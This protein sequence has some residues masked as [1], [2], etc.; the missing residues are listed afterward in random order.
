MPNTHTVRCNRFMYNGWVSYI[1]TSKLTSP[2]IWIVSLPMHKVNVSY[3]SPETMLCFMYHI[4][5]IDIM[6]GKSTQ[7]N[8]TL[9]L[10]YVLA[11]IGRAF[12]GGSLRH[13]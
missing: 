7:I 4:H 11:K 12:S 8:I 13:L 5:V 3:H 9:K 2:N 6:F 1:T 10:N